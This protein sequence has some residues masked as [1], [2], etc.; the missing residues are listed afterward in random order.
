[1]VVSISELGKLTLTLNG[2]AVFTDVQL[3]ASY[4]T[5]IKSNWKHVFMA[6]TGGLNNVHSIDNVTIKEG[7]YSASA[8]SNPN[9]IS[10][11]TTYYVTETAYGCASAPTSF[12]VQVDPA[13][14]LAM[15]VSNDTVCAGTTVA[16]SVGS[17]NPNYAYTWSNNVGTGSSVNV[18]P[19]VSTSYIVVAT[20]TVASSASYGCSTQDTILVV[21]NSLPTITVSPATA[22][23]CAGS[24]QQ[25]SVTAGAVWSSVAGLYTNITGTTPATGNEA[26]V[27]A[28]PSSTTTYTASLTNANGCVGTASTTVTVNPIPVVELSM[29]ANNVCGGTPVTLTATGANTYVWTPGN[30]SGSSI[31]VSPN[32]TTTYT[33]AGYGTGNCSGTASITLNINSTPSAP[34]VTSSGSTTICNGSSVLLSTSSTEGLQW[35][36]NGVAINGATSSTYSASAA[37]SYTITSTSASGCISAASTPIN[38]IVNAVPTVTASSNAVNNTVCKEELVV[39]SATGAATFS[40]D[41]GV[42]SGIAFPAL[43]T[44]TYTVTGTTLQGCSATASVQITVN[45][46]PDM[47]VSGTATICSGSSTVLSVSGDANSYEWNPGTLAGALVTVS[48]TSTT[49]YTVTGTISATGCQNQESVVV[50]V[51]Q[52]T[53]PSFSAVSPICSGAT[54]VAL[55]TTSLNGVDGTWSPALDNTATTL[56]TFTPVAGSCASSSTMEI[57]VN[58]IPVVTVSATPSSINLG[59][60]SL[61]V[62]VGADSYTWSNGMTNDSIYV[63]PVN[64]SSY[65]VTGATSAGCIASDSIEVVVNSCPTVAVVATSSSICIGDSTTLTA[66]GATSYT[67]NGLSGSSTIVVSPTSTTTYVVSGTENGCTVNDTITVVVNQQTLPV[68]TQVA[69]ICSGSTITALPLTSNNGID[70]TW[71]PALDNTATTTYTFTPATGS[72]ASTTTMEIVVNALPVIT[73]VASPEFICSGGSSTLVAAGASTYTWSTSATTNS[74]TVSP[75]TTSTYSVVGTDANGCISSDTVVLTVDQPIAPIFTQVAAICAGDQLSAL[76][77]TSNNGID[78]TWSPALDN[79]ATTTY[80]FTPVVGACAS[81]TTMQIVVNAQPVVSASSSAAIVCSGASATLTATGADTYTWDNGATGAGIS[82][83]P[84]VATTYTVTGTTTAG[85]SSSAAVSVGVLGTPVLTS[86]TTV[87]CS[88]ALVTMTSSVTSGIQWYKN[89]IIITGATAATYSTSSA[90]TYTVKLTACPSTVSNG[91]SITTGSNPSA[92]NAV[93][94]SGSLLLCGPSAQ[95][96]L[97]STVAPSGTTGVQ[98]YLNGSAIS[99]A[100]AQTYTTSTPGSYV[101]RRVQLS[102]GCLSSASTALAV[103]A[104][105]VPTTPVVSLQSG[106]LS[107]CSGATSTLASDVT[108]SASVSLQWY[109]DGVVQ[110]AATAATLVANAAGSYTVKATDVS[111]CASALSNAV[112]LTA[113]PTAVISASSLSIC[114]SAPVTLT[115]NVTNNIQWYKTGVLISGA[116]SATYSATTA[117][118]YTVKSTL[119]PLQVSNSLAVITGSAPAAPTVSTPI[120]A[121]VCSSSP[122]T[123]QSSIAP[124]GTNSLQWYKDG[125]AISGAT[126]QTYSTA[127]AGSYTVRRIQVSSGCPSVSSNAIAVTN[128][129][130]TPSSTSVS[131]Q[132]GSTYICSS[133]TNNVVLVSAVAP[134]ASTG[135]QWYNGST[136]ISGATAQSYTA[137]VAGSY[138][139]RRVTSTGCSSAASNALTITVG[140]IPSTAAITAN[141][142]TTVVCGTTPVTLVSSVAPTASATLQW[143]KDGV[144]VFNGTSQSIST[145]TAGSYT[146]RRIANCPSLASNAIVTTVGTIPAAP[147]VSVQSGSLATCA[148]VPVVLSSSV[149]PGSGTTLQWYSTSTVL[150]NAT[151]QTYSTATAGSYRVKATSGGCTSPYSN[152]LTVSVLSAPGT[153]SISVNTGSLTLCNGSTVTLASAHSITNSIG[154]RWYKDGVQIAGATSQYYTASTPGVYTARRI[155]TATGCLGNAS[156]PL[157]VISCNPIVVNDNNEEQEDATSKLNEELVWDAAVS[158]NPYEQYVTIRLNSESDSDIELTMVDA[159]GKVVSHEVAN[160]KEL[161]STRIGEGL[162]PGIYL[163]SI[164]QDENIKTI[165]VIKQ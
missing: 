40:W 21:V 59:D 80:T 34:I 37:G 134:T 69:A 41:N 77:T 116:T 105:T 96:V 126:A 84:T 157:T 153:A 51:T 42:S 6:R 136:A 18:T 85:C 5:D 46:L 95:V 63:S 141:G 108:P 121:V 97:Q 104:G 103:V 100:T 9:A 32:T 139:V 144:A 8:L 20:D 161:G 90:G 74:V 27:Y 160:I 14:V 16:L 31:V 156:S 152:S 78:G 122:I 162:T 110:S 70:G 10:A 117:G 38:V 107:L 26:T 61:L 158:R 102:S 23:I 3:P 49:V 92:P 137:T 1:V 75:A 145:L 130:S 62:A 142:N 128:G 50:T 81:A 19:L 124:S 118:T 88:A 76:P 94:Q 149:A 35:Y 56:Y 65:T 48:P 89:N 123:L 12:T 150:S 135:L 140:S 43:A 115:S 71:S 30:L 82:V 54:L 147:V 143:Y 165:R 36:L 47:I 114:N 66:S 22:S 106:A 119:C 127:V 33:V 73:I 11:T 53:L 120:G 138:S 29:S 164:R 57:V 109:K 2:S 4:L 79:T 83:S 28:L 101:V 60:S 132:G 86:P 15:S 129:G 13:P 131:T 25:L 148:G 17:A 112:A 125:A 133:T 113:V 45:P 98:W 58:S 55:P 93:V 72:C 64:T 44:T 68:F 159:M 154:V 7:T 111:G 87:S 163:I 24:V 39:L 91:I 151:S 52:P 146:V 99:G 67:W 155:Y